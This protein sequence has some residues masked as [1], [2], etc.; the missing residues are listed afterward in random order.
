[1]SSELLDTA[2]A[3]VNTKAIAYSLT[4]LVYAKFES[5]AED[6]EAA[7]YEIGNLYKI[8]LETIS[9]KDERGD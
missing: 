7:A 2:I 6:L 1:M 5:K 4:K 3:V 8:V 9:P